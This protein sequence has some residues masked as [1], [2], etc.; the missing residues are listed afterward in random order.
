M[1]SS[2]MGMKLYKDK[3]YIIDINFILIKIK[4]Y[5][6][7]TNIKNYKKLCNKILTRS[8]YNLF[9][10]EGFTV[11]IDYEILNLFELKL[12]SMIKDDIRTLLWKYVSD[13]KHEHTYYY[14]E[15]YVINKNMHVIL[16][17][18]GM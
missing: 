2:N 11:D 10:E 13:L 6:V 16:T 3:V 14:I 5:I 17:I 1:Y 7:F 12:Y 18:K 15:T 8:I 4:R 9:M